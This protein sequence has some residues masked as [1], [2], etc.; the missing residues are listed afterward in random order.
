MH[1]YGCI[2]HPQILHWRVFKFAGQGW[3]VF[4]LLVFF[5]GGGVLV[6]VYFDFLAFVFCVLFRLGPYSKVFAVLKLTV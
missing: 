2:S 6:L 1:Y 4:L 3:G 5:L